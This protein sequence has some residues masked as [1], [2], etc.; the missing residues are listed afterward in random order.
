MV[1]LNNNIDIITN[2]TDDYLQ[3]AVESMVGKSV[4][5]D[6]IYAI[7]ILRDLRPTSRKMGRIDTRFFF[8]PKNTL[9]GWE[10][11]WRRLFDEKESSE[12]LVI[13]DT[14][15]NILSPYIEI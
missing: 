12:D 5:V 7:A 14:L 11:A 9:T 13:K 4:K 2:V 10:E 1:V 8:K 6:L 15:C 3:E